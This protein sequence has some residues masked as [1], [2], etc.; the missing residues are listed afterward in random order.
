MKIERLNERCFK[1]QWWSGTFEEAAKGKIR[2]KINEF[3][4]GNLIKEG[5][6]YGIAVH[7]STNGFK[8]FIGVE[9]DRESEVI[10]PKSNYLII[11][12]NNKSAYEVYQ[13]LERKSEYDFKSFFDANIKYD[14]IP[15]KIEKYWYK[16]GAF[17]VTQIEVPINK[18][19]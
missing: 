4:E 19:T 15:I 18:T 7:N 16:E 1:G 12:V 2:E 17:K 14:S 9:A 13:E 6:F 11:E 3:L 5:P 10:I 8:Y